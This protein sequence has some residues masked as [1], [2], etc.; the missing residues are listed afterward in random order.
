MFLALQ[1]RW[2]KMKPIFTFPSF[3]RSRNAYL[4]S[5]RGRVWLIRP[6]LF[7][8]V[9]EASVP[10]LTFMNVPLLHLSCVLF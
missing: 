8:H 3:L 7:C 10:C 2:L 6:M 1:Q 5:S 4:E 9:L